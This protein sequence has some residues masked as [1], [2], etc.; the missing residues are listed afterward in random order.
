[1]FK[2]TMM[3]AVM[4]S[5]SIPVYA[6]RA[7]T[8][9]S[10]GD[11]YKV[12]ISRVRMHKD[13]DESTIT[14]YSQLKPNM[15]MEVREVGAEEVYVAI[16][17]KNTFILNPM[18][19]YGGTIT[20]DKG[21]CWINGQLVNVDGEASAKNVTITSLGDAYTVSVVREHVRL[22]NKERPVTDDAGLC[23]W[24]RAE[25]QSRLEPNMSMAVR[26]NETDPLHVS[27]V[28]NDT[29]VLDDVALFQTDKLIELSGNAC[30]IN[31]KCVDECGDPKE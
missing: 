8:I 5:V 6:G 14:T 22:N 26:G 13:A 16:E 24:E 28:H 15:S 23:I 3:C 9:T 12:F 30:R 29:Q 31:G 2:K 17:H 20:L 11:T 1:M 25:T 19:G 10:L 21:Q 4:M 18:R 7:F 27:I